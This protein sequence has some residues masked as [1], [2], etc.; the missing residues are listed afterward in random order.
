M[1]EPVVPW[2]EAPAREACAAFRTVEAE[3]DARTALTAEVRDMWG[4]T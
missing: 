2:F 3:L 1:C 4:E